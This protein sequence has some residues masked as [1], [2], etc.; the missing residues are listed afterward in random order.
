MKSY[1]QLNIL[2]E[3]W[4][5]IHQ[6]ISDRNDLVGAMNDDSLEGHIWAVEQEMISLEKMMQSFLSTRKTVFPKFG[7]CSDQKIKF[8][9]C[10]HSIQHAND[11]ISYIFPQVSKLTIQKENE[12]LVIKG[13][14]TPANVHKN[15]LNT[16]PLDATT[17]YIACKTLYSLRESFKDEIYQIA[18][19]QKRQG[20]GAVAAVGSGGTGGAQLKQQ[21][22]YTVY[23]GQVIFVTRFVYVSLSHFVETD[24]IVN[25]S[26]SK[27]C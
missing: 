17:D 1:F 25:V 7:L 4:K 26:I 27:F 11:W 15:F 5:N 14:V 10:S 23:S 20:G 19:V 13:F 3:F 2:S 24:I 12:K 21:E 9:F 8:I 22:K 16:I 18:V 6:E